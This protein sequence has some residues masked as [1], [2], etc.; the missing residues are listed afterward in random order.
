V[1]FHDASAD[2]VKR[3]IASPLA[4]QQGAIFVAELIAVVYLGL[5]AWAAERTGVKLLLFPELAAV[6]HDV[7][8]RPHGKW[9][10]QPVRMVVVPTLTAVVGLL[11]TRHARYGVLSILLLVLACL[12]LIRLFRAT[13]SPAISA[14]VL[15]MVLGLRHWTYPP[16]IGIGLAGL[17]IMR[18]AWRRWGPSTEEH[19]E[20]RDAPNP[21]RRGWLPTILVFVLAMGGLGQVT[22]LRFILFPPLIVIAY[23]VFSQAELPRWISRP[24]LVPLS[25]VLTGSVGLLASRL[26]DGSP[27]GV[28]ATL[29]VSMLLLRLLETHFSPA[30]AVAVLP[31]VIPRPDG[32]YVASVATGTMALAL[33]FLCRIHWTSRVPGASREREPSHGA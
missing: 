21:I 17:A 14:G 26:A 3:A 25:C 22:G 7:L 16:A 18:G 29:A 1:T 28:I 8:T 13:M 33:S 20:E 31:F 30:L 27:I 23:E 19:D 11:V 32:W 15:P 9:A 12:A 24:A 2:H 10:S 5:I 6:S 4:S